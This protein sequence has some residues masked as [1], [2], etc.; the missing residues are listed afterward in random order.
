MQPRMHAYAQQNNLM[1]LCDADEYS[2]LLLNEYKNRG[3]KMVSMR[4]FHTFIASAFE[5]YSTAANLLIPEN[6]HTNTCGD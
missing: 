6:G 4:L 3:K 2:V 1:I 5:I